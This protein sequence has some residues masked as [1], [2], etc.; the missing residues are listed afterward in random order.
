MS[1][2]GPEGPLVEDD[3]ASDAFDC[4]DASGEDAWTDDVGFVEEIGPGGDDVDAPAVDSIDLDVDAGV[5]LADDG[6]DVLIDSGADVT[7]DDVVELPQDDTDLAGD[8]ASWVDPRTEPVEL[9][10]DAEPSPPPPETPA[11]EIY[12]DGSLV[13][14]VPIADHLVTVEDVTGSEVYQQWA[15][16]GER[17]DTDLAASTPGGLSLE[18]SPFDRPGTIGDS[19]DVNFWF[20]QNSQLSCGPSSAAQIISDFTGVTHLDE[21]AL[22]A[23]ALEQ[24]WYDPSTGMLPEALASLLDDQGVPSTVMH[25]QGFG[26]IEQYLREGRAV[27]MFLD[28]RDVRPAGDPIIDQDQPENTEADTVD[29]FVRVIGIDREAGIAILADPGYAGG[30]QMEI[31]LDQ[32]EEAWNDNTVKPG[33]GVIDR[34]HMLIVSDGADPTVDDAGQPTTPPATTP[35]TQGTTPPA[36]TTPPQGTTPPAP[37]TPETPTTPAT[38]TTGPSPAPPAS[39]AAGPPM[40]EPGLAPAAPSLPPEP[41][42][43][44]TAPSQPAADMPAR[45]ISLPA[46]APQLAGDVSLP[47]ADAAPAAAAAA[48][49]DDDPRA[50]DD[51]GLFDSVPG[52]V[53]VPVTLA[54]ARIGMALRGR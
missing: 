42:P 52:W 33:Q 20:Q 16:G 6:T 28:A 50:T 26:N 36:P 7:P 18:Y 17:G 48:T 19:G 32:L 40:P 45:G 23:R 8:V 53:I 14:Q 38:P 43:A 22:A 10:L 37:S 12:E 39:P 15:T 24:R 9:R 34:D 44:A 31:P 5:G 30:R 35:Q 13:S 47:S 46:P 54:A 4:S 29:H 25:D 3:L 2:Y 49:A 1:G 11:P 27:V 51:D 41:Q 21:S